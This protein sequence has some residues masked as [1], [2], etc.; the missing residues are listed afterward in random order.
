MDGYK[1][2]R[3]NLLSGRVSQMSQSPKG[4]MM[5]RLLIRDGYEEEP[6]L[7][8]DGDDGSRQAVTVE[9]VRVRP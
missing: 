5:L 8:V 6:P 2:S 9:A 4:A 3:L 7:L 1:E